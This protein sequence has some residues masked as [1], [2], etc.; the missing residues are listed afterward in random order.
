MFWVEKI[1]VS[2]RRE[3][4]LLIAVDLH[5]RCCERIAWRLLCH[6][7]A[8]GGRLS[9]RRTLDPERDLASRRATPLPSYFANVW[10]QLIGDAYCPRFSGHD[11][12]LSVC[13][14][15]EQKKGR[16]QFTPN[17][18]RARKGPTGRLPKLNL[19]SSDFSAF[20]AP[21]L[22]N[23]PPSTRDKPNS[24]GS[25]RSLGPSSP[26]VICVMRRWIDNLS[27][28]T[29]VILI[30]AVVVIAVSIIAWS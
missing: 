15:G 7:L 17:S 9:R 19:S 5:Q 6:L 22:L 23:Y 30:I 13:C 26:R 16:E 28:R 8:S 25:M 21:N 29:R 1:S 4:R 18:T 10:S 24:D 3:Y 11:S 27:M 2:K 12:Q 20:V 14:S